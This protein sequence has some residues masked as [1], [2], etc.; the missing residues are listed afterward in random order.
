MYIIF[1]AALWDVN[2]L[3]K[4]RRRVTE[5]DNNFWNIFEFNIY[6]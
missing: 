3:D 6:G 4:F 5:I 1:R 2:S